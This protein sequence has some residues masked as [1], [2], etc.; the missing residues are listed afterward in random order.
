MPA[1]EPMPFQL[2]EH[3]RKVVQERN[4]KTEWIERALS[5]PERIEPDK[6]DIEL[7][8]SLTPISEFG[9][10]VLRVIYNKQT[11]PLKIV[12]VFFDRTMKGRL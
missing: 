2:T 9:N 11:K 6:E 1:K 10:R 7:E 4:I 8:H 12:T 3:A 5:V